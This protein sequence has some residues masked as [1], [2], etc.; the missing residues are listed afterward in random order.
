MVGY[1]NYYQDHSQTVGNNLRTMIWTQG[2][3]MMNARTCRDSVHWLSIKLSPCLCSHRSFTS[4][5]W[6]DRWLHCL[7]VLDVRS[8]YTAVCCSLRLTSRWWSIS[9]IIHRV[10]LIIHRVGLIIH[11]VGLIIHRGRPIIDVVGL[12]F[13]RGYL[14]INVV[15]LIIHRGY[16]IIHV[17]GLI[18][19]RVINVVGL[20][21]HRVINVVGLINHRRYLIIDGVYLLIHGLNMHILEEAQ[22]VF[23]T[24]WVFY[25]WKHHKKWGWQLH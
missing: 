10:G 22:R 25:F 21:I 5:S 13:H 23:L 18:I 7:H 15:G 4:C 12:L 24:V 14:I 16:L 11:R 19:H 3:C 8:P 20:I 1:L 17:V 6:M 9:L 2:P